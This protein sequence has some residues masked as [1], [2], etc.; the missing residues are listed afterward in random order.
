MAASPLAALDGAITYVADRIDGDSH[1][2]AAEEAKTQVGRDL[3]RAFNWGYGHAGLIVA[4]AKMAHGLA[5]GID[6]PQAPDIPAP[7]PHQEDI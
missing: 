4:G 5:D 1:K 7:P 3:D 2:E 6:V